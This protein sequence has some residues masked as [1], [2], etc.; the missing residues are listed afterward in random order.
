LEAHWEHYK[1][2][3]HG[4]YSKRGRPATNRVSFHTKLNP[5]IKA[6]LASFAKAKKITQ[7]EAIEYLVAKEKFAT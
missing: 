6:S 2:G 1:A 3:R 5:D 7:A 4:V